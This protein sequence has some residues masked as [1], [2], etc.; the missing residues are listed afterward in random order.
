MNILKIHNKHYKIM[1]NIG[2][3]KNIL[4]IVIYKT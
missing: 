2:S 1:A 3:Y 4:N